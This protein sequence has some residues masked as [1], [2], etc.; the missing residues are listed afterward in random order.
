MGSAHSPRPNERA[1]IQRT[2][3]QNTRAQYNLP[4]FERRLA[5]PANREG[6][7]DHFADSSVRKS[8]EVDLALLDRYDALIVTR[9]TASSCAQA[10]T[11]I[12]GGA[13][14]RDSLPKCA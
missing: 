5:Y 13:G 1:I 9:I 11:E 12:N 2:L 3:I 8:M 14:L 4:E 10:Y 6:V 7:P